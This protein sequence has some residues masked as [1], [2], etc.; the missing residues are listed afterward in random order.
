MGAR[1][2]ENDVS[3]RGE[4]GVYLSCRGIAEDCDERHSFVVE[5]IHRD[6]RFCHLHQGEDAFL[7]TC[8]TAGYHRHGGQLLA[9]GQFKGKGDLLAH[10]HTHAAA[11]EAEVQDDQN[12]LSTT[13]GAC[14][15][16]GCLFQSGALLVCQQAD[17]VRDAWRERE[18]VDG[19]HPA[20][21]FLEASGIRN[22]CDSLPGGHVVVEVAVR[23]D[24]IAGVRLGIA[25]LA[26]AHQA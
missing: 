6:C 25:K 21:G 15:R 5:V 12:R 10:D 18:W 24:E 4:A 22:G 23:A 26:A 11:E 1:L 19:L 2:G 14:S 3:E 7:N 17:A 16:Y 8:P 9:C 13:D 20:V